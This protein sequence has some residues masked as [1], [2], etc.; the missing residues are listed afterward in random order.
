[1]LVLSAQAL[2]SGWLV[3][4]PGFTAFKLCGVGPSFFT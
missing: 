4:S 1:M 2:E 3:S